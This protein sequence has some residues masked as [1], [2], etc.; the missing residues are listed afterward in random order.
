MAA[1]NKNS[2]TATIKTPLSV[3]KMQSVLFKQLLTERAIAKL[4]QKTCDKV[5]PY[6]QGRREALESLIDALDLL[7]A[8]NEWEQLQRQ[9]RQGHAVKGA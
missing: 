3:A 6:R 8:F 4:S 2:S 9:L 7:P 5:T 1:K